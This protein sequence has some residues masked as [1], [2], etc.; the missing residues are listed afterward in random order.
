MQDC[1]QRLARDGGARIEQGIPATRA[2]YIFE[3]VFL[4]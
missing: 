1:L 4:E 2:A 3:H